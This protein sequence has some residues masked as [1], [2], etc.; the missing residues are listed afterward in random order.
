[1]KRNAYNYELIK[2]FLD[3]LLESARAKEIQQLIKTDETAMN[4]AKGILI[5]EKKLKN[6]DSIEQYLNQ[7]FEKHNEVIIKSNAPKRVLNF[8]K[9]AASIALI[10]VSF[11]LI[12]FLMQPSLSDLVA[13]ELSEPYPAAIAVRSTNSSDI[14]QKAILQYQQGNYKQ[15]ISLL[16]EQGTPQ[17]TFFRGLSLLYLEEYE[18]SAKEL[19]NSRLIDSRFE[20]QA[21]WY[22]SI[23]FLKSGNELGAK[24]LLQT[25]ESK[26]DHF[27]KKEAQDLLSRIN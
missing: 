20:E 12:R 8:L 26:P 2:D 23:A 5:M 3:G 16:Q 18:R 15:A 14:H 7:Q 6:D 9:I 22:G 27:K 1:M 17:A 4:I 25:I 21:R 13:K 19:A 10:A 11:V 24:E